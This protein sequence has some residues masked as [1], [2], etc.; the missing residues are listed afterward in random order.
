MSALRLEFPDLTK[1][2]EWH[3]SAQL[4]VGQRHFEAAFG[5]VA[6]SVSKKDY[7][8]Y[9]ALSKRLSGRS[10]LEA[11]EEVLVAETAAPQD[12]IV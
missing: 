5:K 4:T 1:T 10:R 2:G 12:A 6:P 7:K 11:P 9:K 3:P 8:I